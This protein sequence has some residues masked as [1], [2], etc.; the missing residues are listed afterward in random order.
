MTAD[1]SSETGP[2][3]MSQA[4][5]AVRSPATKVSLLARLSLA[6]VRIGRKIGLGFA[7]VLVLTVGVSFLGWNGLRQVGAQFEKT[8]AIV[9]LADKFVDIRN[10]QKDY[11]LRGEEGSYSGAKEK[12]KP[13]RE[14]A[15]SLRTLFDSVDGQALIDGLKAEID[16]YETELDRYHGLEEQ[17]RAA[18][19]RMRKRLAE[20]EAATDKLRQEQAHQYKQLS[21]K[22]AALEEKRDQLLNVAGQSKTLSTLA[23]DI[24]I[25]V[26]KFQLTGDPAHAEKFKLLAQKL[27]FNLETLKA[28]LGENGADQLPETVFAL[29]KNL[30][31]QFDQLADFLANGKKA[32]ALDAAKA[33]EKSTQQIKNVLHSISAVQESGF[34]MIADGTQSAKEDMEFRQ[35][36]AQDANRL[37]ETVQKTRI[38]QQQYLANPSEE[39]AQDVRFWIDEINGKT[40]TLGERLIE[41]DAK[42]AVKKIAESAAGYL[43]EFESVVTFTTDQVESDQAMGTASQTLNARIAKTKADEKAAMTL[44]RD[45]SGLFSIVGSVIALVLGVI[46]AF[47]ISRSITTPLSYITGSMRRLADGD[48]SIVLKNRRL[49]TRSAIYPAPCRSSSKRPSKWRVC[50]AN[51][52]KR[53]VRPKK[54]NGPR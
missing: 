26:E 12:I 27:G 3:D 9:L 13:L 48:T 28:L 25:E 35:G 7:V 42:A 5:D 31:T 17:K 54:K 41:E 16:R 29:A 4:P 24:L 47:F 33:L 38:S 53:I 14:E 2:Q 43:G 51:R 11:Q 32:E 45:T 40:K 22:L 8:D 34:D 49:K 10:D 44:Q 23:S 36:V 19:G 37:I 18:L 20:M 21:E 30:T 15:N 39:A 52:K 46:F 1:I 50:A 6:N